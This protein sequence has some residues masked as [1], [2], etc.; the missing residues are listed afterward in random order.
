MIMK[1]H[2]LV[3]ASKRAWLIRNV[4]EILKT[5][6]VMDL[7][8]VFY[9]HFIDLCFVELQKYLFILYL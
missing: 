7:A 9:V 1:F 2:I 4:N 8:V 6:K 3:I 5:N